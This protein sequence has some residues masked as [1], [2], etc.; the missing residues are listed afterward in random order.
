MEEEKEEKLMEKEDT[1]YPFRY[2]Y[3]FLNYYL[4]SFLNKY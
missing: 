1:D 4:N 3:N 2:T